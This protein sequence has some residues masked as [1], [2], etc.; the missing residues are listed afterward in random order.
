VPRLAW[1]PFTGP[2]HVVACARG[3][4]ALVGVHPERPPVPLAA[5][6]STDASTTTLL[7]DGRGSVVRSKPGQPDVGSV[8]YSRVPRGPRPEHSVRSPD[9]SRQTQ[10]SRGRVGER[11]TGRLVGQANLMRNTPDPTP[12]PALRDQARR[13]RP[14]SRRG[15]APR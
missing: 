9:P 12:Y 3:P 10:V 5:V 4:R 8:D 15:A 14:V 11:F 1:V 13:F 2:V 6:G 7:A